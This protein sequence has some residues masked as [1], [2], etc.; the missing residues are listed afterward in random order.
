MTGN[1]NFLI[2]NVGSETSLL[3]S[4]MEIEKNHIFVPSPL[5]L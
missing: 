5:Y 1:V 3:D 4:N 2:Q